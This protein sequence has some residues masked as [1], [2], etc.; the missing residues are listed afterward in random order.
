MTYWECTQLDGNHL[1][2]SAGRCLQDAVFFGDSVV[3]SLFIVFI[4]ALV[5]YK[6]NLPKGFALPAGTVLA[7]ALTLNTGATTF[8]ILSLIGL[9]LNF[10]MFG[11][12][13][14]SKLTGN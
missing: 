3:F 10:A 9:G 14:W 1:F 13:I 11:L 2:A 7:I 4:F 12:V 8:L 5:V 6:F